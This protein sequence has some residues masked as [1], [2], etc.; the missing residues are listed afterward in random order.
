MNESSKISRRA[1]A[2]QAALGM[3]GVL[4]YN[5]RTLA[6]DTQ[7]TVGMAGRVIIGMQTYS[8]RDRSLDEAIL[9]MRELEI[10]HCVLWAGHIEPVEYRWK[11]GLSPERLRENRENM[12]KWRDTLSMDDI[13]NVR[14]KLGRAG[15]AILAYNP[16][17]KDNISDHELDQ[18]FQIAK[19]LGTD[20]INTSATVSVMG[21]VDHVA[22]QYGIRV[23]MHNHANVD[24]PNEFAT[25]DSFARGM[26]GKSDLIGINLDTGHF[27]AANFDP[28]LYLKENHKQVFSLDLK[29]RKAN[30]GPRT[31][32]G[33]GDTPLAD[34]LLLIREKGWDIP[35]FIEYEY[36]GGDTI[37]ELRRCVAYC[38]GV[39]DR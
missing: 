34:I 15:I 22:R 32:F 18:A 12:R 28:L 11:R 10:K 14:E 5:A 25:P 13:A 27:T 29:D 9:A 35:A 33:E 19:T 21:R 8:L 36:E 38:K 4:L 37:E 39:L 24:N 20:T 31:P 30:Q 6:M 1:W 7:T 26:A 3:A 2:K 17:I 16:D 23:G